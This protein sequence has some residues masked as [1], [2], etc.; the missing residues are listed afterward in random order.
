MFLFIILKLKL[1]RIV[2]N[3]TS[4]NFFNDDLFLS[5]YC[6]NSSNFFVCVDKKKFLNRRP[7]EDHL[8]LMMDLWSGL[9]LSIITV[10]AIHFLLQLS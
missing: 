10:L 4:L 6:F 5:D 8:S 2:F 7:K 1:Q 9:T 3:H